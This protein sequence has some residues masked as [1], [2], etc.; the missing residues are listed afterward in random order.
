MARVKIL[1]NVY[2]RGEVQF[3]RDEI[4]ELE[5]PDLAKALRRSWAVELPDAT[6]PVAEKPTREAGEKKGRKGA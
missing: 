1:Q 3:R 4:T 2:Q 5:G 6:E